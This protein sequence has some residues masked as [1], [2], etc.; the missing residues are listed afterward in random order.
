MKRL[1]Y[2]PGFEVKDINWL[3]FALL[4][5]DKLEPIIPWS[6]D[7]YL[8]TLFSRLSNDT[9][10]IQIHRPQDEEGERASYDALE[11]IEKILEHPERF[12]Y[13]RSISRIS[14]WKNPLNH[15]Y[16]LFQD[17]YTYPWEDFC[18]SNKLATKTKEGIKMSGELAYIYMALL[19]QA[20]A[21]SKELSP[22]TDKPRLDLLSVLSRRVVAPTS[23]RINL[24]KS[25]L[26]LKLP[27]NITHINIDE[28]IK[29]RNKRGYKERLSAFHEEIENFYN[30]LEDG[31]TAT[32]FVKSFS[33][34]YNEFTGEILKLGMGVIGLGLGVWILVDSA[35]STSA[36]YTKEMLGGLSLMIGSTIS[37]KKTWKN[38]KTKR[39]CRKYIASLRHIR[40]SFDG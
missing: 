28:I 7:D 30:K 19:A 2:Y 10:L 29:F 26:E 23:K 8:S 35:Q 17:K 22:I 14:R 18:E 3:K 25:V 13:M 27:A 24:A 39:Y 6:G 1:I 20:V 4:Y 5:L 9:D 32:D 15:T 16:T 31:K 11:I 34:I 37:I 12:M 21:D 38:T 36:K 40:P 33:R